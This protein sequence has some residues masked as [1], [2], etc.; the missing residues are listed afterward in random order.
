[1]RGLKNYRNILVTSSNSI[2]LFRNSCSNT[3]ISLK[4]RSQ[5]LKKRKRK[6]KKISSLEYQQR[7]L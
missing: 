3:S 4:R 1:M 2:L 7:S 6:L 5:R